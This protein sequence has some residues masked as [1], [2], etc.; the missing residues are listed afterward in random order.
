MT[1]RTV[2]WLLALAIA[3]A[4]LVAPPA[5][6][7][8]AVEIDVNSLTPQV[9]D[10]SK[11][12][13]R[14]TLTGTLRN[15]SDQPIGNVSVH[16]WR[17]TEPLTDHDELEQALTSE[18]QDPLGRRLPEGTEDPGNYQYVGDLAPSSAVDFT[19][20]A[21]VADLTL[22]SDGYAY[23][24]GAHARGNLPTG[25]RVTVAR[26]RVLAVASQSPLPVTTVVKLAPPPSLLD[27]TDFQDDSLASQLT[28]DLEQL[29][30]AAEQ[31]GMQVLLDP[32]LLVELDALAGEHTVAGQP[33]PANPGAK[34]FRERIDALIADGRVLRLPF[35]N[36]DL[37]RLY[38]AADLGKFETALSWPKTA[39]DAAGLDAVAQ[40]PLAADLGNYASQDLALILGM[41][42][43]KTI[44]GDNVQASG[45]IKDTKQAVKAKVFR[46]TDPQ[47]PGIPP[48]NTTS[49]A[50]IQGRRLTEE[51]L[52][53]S[54][55]VHLVRSASQ[56]AAGSPIPKLEQTSD[57][58][59]VRSPARFEDAPATAAT[60]PLLTAELDDL[61]G[62]AH[63][64]EELTSTDRG[65]ANATIASRAA[66]GSFAT[67]EQALAFMQATPVEQLDVDQIGLSVPGQVVVGSDTNFFPVTI[68]NPLSV[69]IT[70]RVSFTSDAL[71]RLS[72]A[73]SDPVTITPGEHRTINV[74]TSTR[75][76][77]VVTV[78]A[79]LET[80]AGTRLGTQ[81]PVEIT[82]TGL[83]R[84]GWI[85]IMISG[86][87]VLG[88]TFLR[89]RAVR[90]ERSREN[91][92]QQ[93]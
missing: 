83:G 55:T 34:R 93:R 60:W 42:G 44:F 12:D 81:V 23:R 78:R 67:Q 58:P 38:A 85:I 76:N 69:A 21:T 71:N 1:R 57:L 17:A 31:P 68:N 53:P 51:L 20:S 4:G 40:L 27:G 7:D 15:D 73:T 66:S 48:G 79:Q 8:G 46:V 28:D 3:L 22:E 62:E 50:Q 13:Q 82:A 47:L 52:S 33:A 19:V 35:G 86:A 77:G 59:E 92:E 61:F 72:V 2:M 32:S 36:P 80:T 41:H 24:L 89:I 26:A 84:V 11:P 6:A 39:L 70:V 5:R 64:L 10:L 29:L 43:Y 75:S 56:I 65:T 9:L 91:R 16:F 37:P 74:T 87:V 88:G 30:A 49:A 54:R 63:L 18:P 25:E 14:V 45:I 90:R